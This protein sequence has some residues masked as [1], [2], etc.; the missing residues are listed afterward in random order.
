MRVLVTG[1]SGFIGRNVLPALPRDWDVVAT[2]RRDDAFPAFVRDR[3]LAHVKALKA[4]LAEPAGLAALDERARTFD[5]CVYLAANGD[6]AYSDHAP[7]DDLRANALA[8]V[9]TLAGCKFGHF[10]FFSSGAVYDGLHGAVGPESAVRPTLPYAISKWASERY[11]MHA[12]KRGRVGT[13][14]IARFF[15][16]YGPYEAPR[17]IYGR[18]VRQFAIERSPRFSIRGDG[19]NLIDA[20]YVDDTVR[21]VRAILA[22]PEETRT[23]DLC[24]GT[25]VTLTEL[26]RTAARRFGVEPQIEYVGAVPEYIEFNSADRTME[27]GF[28]FRPGVP[29]AD[30]LER[31]RAWMETEGRA[32]VERSN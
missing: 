11:V 30:G 2:Y 31:F 19:R 32:V 17:K 16:A 27:K 15:G 22:K 24:S 7:A 9:N 13:A 14:S 26:V 21:A 1:A 4:D 25:P 29:L 3:G 10:L 18:L 12:V 28:G 8:I 5:A 23:F 6:P 20:M